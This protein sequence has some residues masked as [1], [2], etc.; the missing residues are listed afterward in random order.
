MKAPSKKSI[1]AKGELDSEMLKV[2]SSMAV[3]L[4]QTAIKFS[5]AQKQH[6]LKEFARVYQCK[7]K[8]L[9]TAFNDASRTKKRELEKQARKRGARFRNGPTAAMARLDVPV[10]VCCVGHP[11]ITNKAQCEA[12]SPPGIWAC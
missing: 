3:A 12:M 2:I 8:S 1:S 10:V 7:T 5:P 4:A 9:G 6:V 11:Q